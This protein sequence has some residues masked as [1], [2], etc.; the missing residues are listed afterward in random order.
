MGQANRFHAH[1][2]PFNLIGLHFSGLLL[3]IKR[4][5]TA[6][7]VAVPLRARTK[8]EV[9]AELVRLAAPNSPVHDQLLDA[10]RVRES[11]FP[12]ALGDGVA[13][14]HVRTALVNKLTMS[15]CVLDDPIAFGA[16]DGTPVDVLFLLLSPAQSPSEHLGALR[17]LSQLVA[18]ADVLFA[19]RHATNEQEFV[20]VVNAAGPA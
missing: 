7:R 12:I 2:K 13:F 4:L 5:L 11:V 18:N 1:R 3:P 16:S 8:D 6:D 20:A 15:A 10:V 14:P 17:S 9:L 19:L